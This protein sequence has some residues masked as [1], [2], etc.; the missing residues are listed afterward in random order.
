MAEVYDVRT[1]LTRPTDERAL[2]ASMSEA[3]YALVCRTDWREADAKPG[4]SKTAR[5][6]LYSIALTFRRPVK[7]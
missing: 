7:V 1:G 5:D 3:G 6:R 4:A 2:V